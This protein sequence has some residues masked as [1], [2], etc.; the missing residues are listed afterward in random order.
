MLFSAGNHR[1]MHVAVMFLLL[2]AILLLVMALMSV[3]E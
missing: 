2:T 3:V 1:R